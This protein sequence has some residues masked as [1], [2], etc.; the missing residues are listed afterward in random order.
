VDGRDHS[1]RHPWAFKGSATPFDQEILVANYPV[2]TAVSVSVNP[3][4]PKRA[5]VDEWDPGYTKR[6]LKAFKQ[7]P[8]VRQVLAKKY[9][10]RMLN[11]LLWAGGGILLSVVVSFLGQSF[12]LAYVAFTGAIIFGGINFFAGLFGWLKN[13]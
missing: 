4:N 12:G 10:S 6:K 11:G 1:I 3:K 5:W 9:R 7:R 13:L 2:G 8:E